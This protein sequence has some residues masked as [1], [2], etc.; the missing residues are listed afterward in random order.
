[1]NERID[2]NL[3]NH[4]IRTAEEAYDYVIKRWG[5]IKFAQ[6]TVYDW[7]WSEDFDILCSH[8]C[9]LTKGHIRLV[10]LQRFGVKP[11][12]WYPQTSTP[13]HFY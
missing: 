12:P 7:L 10:V 9:D 2:E 13:H 4:I 11:W 6:S 3:L 8:L 5:N 1:M